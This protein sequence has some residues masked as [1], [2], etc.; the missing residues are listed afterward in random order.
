MYPDAY[1]NYSH[2]H[3]LCHIRSQL[4]NTEETIGHVK[5]GIIF[6]FIGNSQW[7]LYNTQSILIGCSTLSQEYCK[8]IGDVGKSWEGNFVHQHALFLATSDNIKYSSVNFYSCSSQTLIQIHPSL[9]FPSIVTAQA[10]QWSKDIQVIQ[11]DK[12]LVH[13]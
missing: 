12:S 2:I 9:I 10:Y 11:L 4:Q 5:I 7:C 1:T 3:K 8:L 6:L 13:S